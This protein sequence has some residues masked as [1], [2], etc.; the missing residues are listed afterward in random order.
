MDM[1]RA[2][3]SLNVCISRLFNTYGPHMDP[4]DGR[5]ISNFILQ[6][7]KGEALTL[8]GDGKQ[9]RS[10]CYV[11]DTIAGLVALMNSTELGPVNI[12]NPS[13]RTV[14][15]AA[16]IIKE[17]TKSASELVHKPL[18]K[19]DPTRRRPDITIAQTKLNWSPQVSFEEGLKKTIAYFSETL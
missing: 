3:P 4:K 14:L 7:L 10:F 9:T 13:E 5:V 2:K 1:H 15:D 18:P 19:D 6:A 16:V 17:A 12:G 8:Y 11:D